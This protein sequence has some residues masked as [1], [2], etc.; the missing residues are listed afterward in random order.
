MAAVWVIDGALELIGNARVANPLATSVGHNGCGSDVIIDIIVGVA[1]RAIVSVHSVDVRRRV[2]FITDKMIVV[3]VVVLGNVKHSRI[4]GI[5][6][7]IAMV[8]SLKLVVV[9]NI[10]H[11][12]IVGIVV[13]V[14]IV[15]SLNQGA[16]ET[17]ATSKATRAA[18][19]AANSSTSMGS[20]S[21]RASSA[22]GRSS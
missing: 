11:T 6:V 7:K 9:G 10:K 8:R 12:S 15:R 18:T 1:A 21:R 3:P 16:S 19:R 14:A 4:I 5:V 20:K 22:R 13:I 2:V 17:G